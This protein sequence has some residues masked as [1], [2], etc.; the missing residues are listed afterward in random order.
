MVGPSDSAPAQPLICIVDDDCPV[1]TA[2]GNLL[3]SAGYAAAV[4]ES[5]EELLASGLTG[6]IDC[7]VLDVKLGGMNG[8]ALHQRL[9]AL[10]PGMPVIFISGHGDDA[11]E[12]RA[13][14]AGAIAF[15]RKPIDVDALLACIHAALTGGEDGA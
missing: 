14:L 15:L 2:L 12:Q 9:L 7:A 1:R 10:R 5:A 11:M 13:L 8:Y 6:A 4:F 3:H